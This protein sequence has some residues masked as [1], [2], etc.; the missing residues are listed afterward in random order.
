M[1]A[2]LQSVRPV[3]KHTAADQGRR[4]QVCGLH[5]ESTPPASH[6]ATLFANTSDGERVI[7]LYLCQEHL[8][9]IHAHIERRRRDPQDRLA[10]DVAMTLEVHRNTQP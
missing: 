3:S 10:H 1:R 7:V 9:A 2:R 4:C 6:R 5:R 8:G